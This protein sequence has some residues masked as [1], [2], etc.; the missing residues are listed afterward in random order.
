MGTRLASAAVAGAC[1]DVCATACASD[2]VACPLTAVTWVSGAFLLVS[3][4]RCE[5]PVAPVKVAKT[6]KRPRIVVQYRDR[7]IVFSLRL[8]SKA[9]ILASMPIVSHALA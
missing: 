3:E 8:S 2:P 1:G 4:D 6:S 9:V 5:Q 7:L